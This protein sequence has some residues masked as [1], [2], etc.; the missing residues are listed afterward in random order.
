MRHDRAVVEINIV[1]KLPEV[2][3][4]GNYVKETSYLYQVRLSHQAHSSTCI[5]GTVLPN[6][7]AQCPKVPNEINRA[8]EGCKNSSSAM[9]TVD[10]PRQRYVQFPPL[11]IAALVPFIAAR[12]S[13]TNQYPL[14]EDHPEHGEKSLDTQNDYEA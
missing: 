10:N 5:N 2:E 4:H 8:R 7:R 12:A 3:T 1:S 13:A 9:P 6:L 11:T 14:C